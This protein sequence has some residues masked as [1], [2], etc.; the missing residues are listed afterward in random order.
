M[1]LNK[2]ITKQ[3]T[4]IENEDNINIKFE[5]INKLHKI[6]DKEETKLEKYLEKLNRSSAT[7]YD[8]LE[9]DQLTSKF[10][11]SDNLEKKIKYYFA[12]SNKID[13]IIDNITL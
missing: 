5:S 6:I 3:I 12:I 10:D 9:F 1:E 13:S 7:K 11:K 2:N 8:D 4:E